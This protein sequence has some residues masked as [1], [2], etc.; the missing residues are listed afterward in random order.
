MADAGLRAQFQGAG[1]EV[2]L[3]D[4]P[5]QFAA[6]IRAETAKW[7]RLIQIAGVKAE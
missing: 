3:S 1:S 4:S 7:A 5:E 6:F 2:E